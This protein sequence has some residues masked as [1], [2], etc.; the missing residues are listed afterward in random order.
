MFTNIKR[1][2]Y[3]HIN[4][5][6]LVTTP[7]SYY[8]IANYDNKWYVFIFKKELFHSHNKLFDD[9]NSPNCKRSLIFAQIKSL[10]F[11]WLYRLHSFIFYII[12]LTLYRLV[13]GCL[14]QLHV[15]TASQYLVYFWPKFKTENILTRCS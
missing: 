7:S 3:T 15:L 2:I 6:V 9:T 10:R 8:N 5:K 14:I 4:R 12:Y 13:W 11:F 1:S